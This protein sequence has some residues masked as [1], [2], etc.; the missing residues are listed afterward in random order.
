M[1]AYESWKSVLPR[2]YIIGPESVKDK[3]DELLMAVVFDYPDELC[4]RVFK[5]CLINE[6]GFLMSL[7]NKVDLAVRIG[8]NGTV[9]FS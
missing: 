1:D 5:E 8:G 6:M 3:Q 4:R 9:T 7:F 2:S